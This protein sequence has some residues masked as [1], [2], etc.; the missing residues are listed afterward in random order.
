MPLGMY[1]VR[2]R[3]TRLP[4]AKPHAERDRGHSYIES[5][6]TLEKAFAEALERNRERLDAQREEVKRLGE[7]R[8]AQKQRHK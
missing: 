2:F 1:R 8:R 3:R 4:S 6:A 7:I 5:A